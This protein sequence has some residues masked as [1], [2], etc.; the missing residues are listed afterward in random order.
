[1]DITAKID[2]ILNESSWKKGQWIVQHRNDNNEYG[3]LIDQLKNGSWSVVSKSDETVGGK[4]TKKTTKG[5]YPAPEVID[6][7]KVPPK[8]KE[9][10]L[11]KMK[12][13]GVQ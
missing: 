2:G 9:K 5:W 8:I 7:N 3:I 11:K 4:A 13:L 6:V 1:M 10:V 12:E